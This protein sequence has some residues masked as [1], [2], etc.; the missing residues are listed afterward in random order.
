MPTDETLSNNLTGTVDAVCN[1]QHPTE[2]GINEGV[3][4]DDVCTVPPERCVIIGTAVWL[5]ASNN[6]T[7]VVDGAGYAVSRR[8]GQT[9]QIV[10]L[11]VS[12][13]KGMN[14]TC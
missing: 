7:G 10:H 1:R 5:G 8:S 2:R 6:I 12:E 3:E 4:V 11:F 9:A 14:C 13:Q